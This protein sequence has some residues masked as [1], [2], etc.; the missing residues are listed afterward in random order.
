MKEM[1]LRSSGTAS[2]AP[3]ARLPVS[4]TESEALSVWIKMSLSKPRQAAA[5]ENAFAL[6][7]D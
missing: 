7:Y 6:A 3:G 2:V 4:P 1:R 5:K